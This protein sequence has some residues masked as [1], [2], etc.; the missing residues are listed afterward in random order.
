MP[1][2]TYYQ[3]TQKNMPVNDVIVLNYCVMT[4][5]LITH[6]KHFSGS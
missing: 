4:E 5:E 1:C 3:G 6:M 2:A